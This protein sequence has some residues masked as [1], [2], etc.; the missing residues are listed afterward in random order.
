MTRDSRLRTHVEVGILEGEAALEELGPEWQELQ[1]RVPLVPAPYRLLCH[2]ARRSKA[3]GIR[4][5]TARAGG[6]LVLVWPFKTV[7]QGP[8]RILSRLGGV[9][10]PTDQPLAETGLPPTVWTEAWRALLDL[11]EVDVISLPS[12]PRSSPFVRL[13]GRAAPLHP[14]AEACSID[15]DTWDDAEAWRASLSKNRRKALRRHRRKLTEQGEV[16]FEPLYDLSS[17]RTALAQAL[18]W[19]SEWLREQGAFGRSFSTPWLEQ[20]LLDAASDP[21]LRESLGVFRLRAGARTVAVEVGLVDAS[22]FQSW[23]GAYDPEL[24]T[25]GPGSQ[26]TAEV[27]GWCKDQDLACY[28]FLAPASPFKQSWSTTTTGMVALHLARSRR[29]RL[30]L[31][32]L[33]EGR[34]AA[35]AAW[36]LLP[37]EARGGRGA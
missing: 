29:G 33:R 35:K 31:P 20:A 27:I 11:G 30:L 5:L 34:A 25:H 14:H 21:A 17:R 8:V 10:Q 1:Q 2:V 4:V 13:A 36:E 7:R 15:L 6:R 37:D 3:S 26:L 19:K 24:G 18:G 12:L 9:L 28:D 16:R 32:L 23:L 22:V